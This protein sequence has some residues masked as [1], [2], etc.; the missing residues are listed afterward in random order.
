MDVVECEGSLSMEGAGVAGCQLKLE[1]RPRRQSTERESYLRFAKTRHSISSG[2]DGPHPL[3]QGSKGDTHCASAKAVNDEEYAGKDTKTSLDCATIALKV[4]KSSMRKQA[5]IRG[6]SDQGVVEHGDQE[7]SGTKQ[8]DNSNYEHVPDKD[9]WR[10]ETAAA[11][12]SEPGWPNSVHCGDPRSEADSGSYHGQSVGLGPQCSGDSG[13]TQ[14][15]CISSDISSSECDSGAEDGECK[16]GDAMCD[17][18]QEMICQEDGGVGS[19]GSSSLESGPEQTQGGKLA[20]LSSD[21]GIS[22]GSPGQMNSDTEPCGPQQEEKLTKNI[23]QIEALLKRINDENKKTKEVL[24]RIDRG[25]FRKEKKLVEIKPYLVKKEVEAMEVKKEDEKEEEPAEPTTKSR[26]SFS[27]SWANDKAEDITWASSMEQKRYPIVVFSPL[28]LSQ[29]SPNPVGSR[30]HLTFKV[31]QADAK[32]VSQIFHA[33]GFHEVGSLNQDFNLMW[34]GSHPKPQSFKSMLPHQRVNHFPRSYELTRKDRMYK[35][36]ERLQIAKG[37]KHFNFI[38]KTFMIPNEYSEFAATHHRMRGAWIVKPVASSRGRGIFIV[39]HPNQVPLDEPMVVG[40]YIDNPLLIN[41]HKSD[42]RLYVLVTSYDPLI[43]YLYEEGLVRFATVKYDHTGKNL[44]NPCMHLCNYSINKY[45]SDYIKSA[46]PDIDDQGHKWSLSAFLKHL[47]AN[48]IDTVQ[49]MQSIEDVIIKSILSVEF[50]VNSAS[51]MFVPHRNN[52]FELYGFD[53]LIDSDLKPWLIEVNLSPSL[54][55]EAPIDMKIKSAM[56]SD[57][58]SVVG[59]PAIDPVLKRAQFNQKI[60]NLTQDDTSKKLN[61]R[62]V[63]AETRRYAAIRLAASTSSLSQELSKMIRDAKEQNA[64]RKGWVRIFP[65][66]ETW[67]NYGAL[68]EYS[69]SNNLVLHEHLFPDVMMKPA[70][71][72][73]SRF[74]DGFNEARKRSQ[75]AGPGKFEKRV[76]K[77]ESFDKTPKSPKLRGE[78]ET[79]DSDEKPKKPTPGELRVAQYEKHLEKGHRTTIKNKREK[80]LEKLAKQRTEKKERS[81]VLKEKM[82]KMIE[83]GLQLSE[84]QAR[85]AFTVYLQ[86]IL[87]RL[88]D[89]DEENGDSSQIELVLK[90]L[91]KAALSLRESYMLKAPNSKLCGK[92]K[93]AVVAKELGDFLGHYKRETELFT[94]FREESGMVPRHIFEEFIAFASD[95]D[96]EDVLTLQTKLYRCAHIFLGKCLPPVTSRRNPLLRTAYGISP[97]RN[98]RDRQC[99]MRMSARANPPISPQYALP[100]PG[101]ARCLDIQTTSPVPHS[102][103]SLD[104]IPEDPTVPS[105]QRHVPKFEK[106][107]EYLPRVSSAPS[108]T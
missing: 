101:P 43:I 36:I 99:S 70:N 92:D 100:P 9:E 76:L 93:A 35:N 29:P 17:T 97:D 56:I 48:N 12:E 73:R 51:K 39:N 104:D 46:D 41:G 40:K 20:H 18:K 59:I 82:V 105:R 30:Y 67:N 83:S 27:G 88:S 34:T 44:W 61:Q 91:Q 57:L 37:P 7:K 5:A 4:L 69:S 81:A 98:L 107:K 11:V 19:S 22:D 90:F 49:L 15:D 106:N 78:E 72:V 62:N 3:T 103:E 31:V 23:S 64:R 53:I 8:E 87:Q 28:A 84:Y 95:S 2:R 94:V 45:H 86:C 96:L 68:L 85:K 71:R 42:L 58:L 52:C 14:A 108:Q 25:E 63:S 47:K 24:E 1:D 102:S 6:G 79:S 77:E 33:H 54:N 65:T 75:S 13:W 80:D 60:N 38:P 26:V 89:F 66:A 55:T 50:P 32:I 74:K 16:E 10:I 21:S